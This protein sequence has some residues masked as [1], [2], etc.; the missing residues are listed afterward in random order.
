MVDLD[1]SYVPATTKDFMLDEITLVCVGGCVR[2]RAR[3]RVCVD[4][5]AN[6]LSK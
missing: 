4:F 3:A 6:G 2:V 1:I 5:T